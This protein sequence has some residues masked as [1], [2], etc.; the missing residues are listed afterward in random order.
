MKPAHPGQVGYEAVGVVDCLLG[1]SPQEIRGSSWRHSA[2]PPSHLQTH[3]A[4]TLTFAPVLYFWTC[5][6][7]YLKELSPLLPSRHASHDLSGPESSPKDALSRLPA[8]IALWR[9]RPRHRPLLTPSRYHVH[10]IQHRISLHTSPPIPH[11]SPL[12]PL[13]LEPPNAPKCLLPT[14]PPLKNA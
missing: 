7:A 11:I 12:S 9:P 2:D 3:Y 4:G 14:S 10:L 8:T 5:T 6:A 1:V 13:L